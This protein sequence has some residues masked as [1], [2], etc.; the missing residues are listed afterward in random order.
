MIFVNGLPLGLVELKNPADED[1]D[2]WDAYQQIGTHRARSRRYFPT[3]RCFGA[4]AS[5]EELLRQAPIQAA[6]RGALRNELT[7][8]SGPIYYESRLAKLDL[9]DAEKPRLD[10]DSEEVTEGEE[11]ERKERLKSMSRRICVELYDEIVKLRPDWHSDSDEEGALKVVMTGSASD[12]AGWQQHVRSKRGPEAIAKRF[13]YSG[14]VDSSASPLGVA[15]VEQG[16]FERVRDVA[17]GGPPGAWR[18]SQC[19]P[20]G[21][22]AWSVTFPR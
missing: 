16:K 10:D 14:D 15:V 2:T 12:P 9:R 17:P 19:R 21:C 4:F 5:C 18:S 13:K 6:D 22:A 7:R 1:A 3:T 20:P 11:V 8:A